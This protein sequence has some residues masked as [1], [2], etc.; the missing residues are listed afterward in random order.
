MEQTLQLKSYNPR[1]STA[2]DSWLSAPQSVTLAST[3]VHVWR[4]SL[5]QS[6]EKLTFYSSLLTPDERQRAD[7]FIFERDRQRFISARGILRS[8]LGKYLEQAPEKLRF[9][10]SEYGKPAIKH[11]ADSDLRFNVSHSHE[12]VLY[13]FTR[14]RAIGVDVEHI[15]EDR[16]TQQIAERFF[17]AQE[18]ATFLSIPSD[19][20]TE[21][22]FNCWTRKEAYI[23]GRGEGLSFPLDRFDVSLAPGSPAELL[24][25]REPE[26]SLSQAWS[27]QEITSGSGYAAAVAVEG[28]RNWTVS[29]WQWE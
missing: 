9:S 24:E 14:D 20:Q 10:Y 11:P 5:V 22:F 19:K 26:N 29:C 27:L 13:A 28:V 18:V 8:L 23:K 7:R 25:C 1:R 12:V 4:A 17:S 6:L 21:A 16:A 2:K 15:G 3:D